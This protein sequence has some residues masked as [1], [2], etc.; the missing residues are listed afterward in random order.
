MASL[1]SKA[2]HKNF[3]LREWLRNLKQN[4]SA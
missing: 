4:L 2:K 1:D 3:L